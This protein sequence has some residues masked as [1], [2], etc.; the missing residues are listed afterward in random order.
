MCTLKELG[1]EK[2]SSFWNK[3][4][5]SRSNWELPLNM[6][7]WWYTVFAIF[8]SVK[9]KTYR[10]NTVFLSEELFKIT[11]QNGLNYTN[12]FLWTSKTYTRVTDKVYSFSPRPL[13]S[14]LA[15]LKNILEHEE[16]TYRNQEFSQLCISNYCFI[17]NIFSPKRRGKW[18]WWH[19]IIGAF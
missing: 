6:A 19:L 5:I 16:W 4:V 10:R 8:P 2:K 9:L 14:L 3:M 15:I 13:N 11:F 1:H 18:H 17:S 7:L 12:R